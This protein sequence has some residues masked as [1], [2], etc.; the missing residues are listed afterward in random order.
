MTA[1]DSFCSTTTA[2]AFMAT[3]MLPVIAPKK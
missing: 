3:S 1:R 2:L